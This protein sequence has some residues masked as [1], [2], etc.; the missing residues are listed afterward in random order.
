MRKLIL[1]MAALIAAIA[2]TQS[3]RAEGPEAC[4]PTAKNA[5]Y[6]LEKASGDAAQALQ[7]WLHYCPNADQMVRYAEELR[8]AKADPNPQAAPSAAPATPAP[9]A[10][11]SPAPASKPKSGP[12]G[13]WAQ[14]G[15]KNYSDR[16]GFDDFTDTLV[17]RED[18]T[19]EATTRYKV[20][21][22]PGWH[23]KGCGEGATQGVEV[24]TAKFTVTVSG[25][26]VT[27]ARQGQAI[28]TRFEPPCWQYEQ[29]A[30]PLDKPWVLTWTNNRLKDQDGEYFRQPD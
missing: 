8:K 20:T 24:M 16:S 1:P 10:A 23:L 14:S 12:Y 18:G 3:A 2:A 26:T 5:K 13:T 17:I 6:Q 27:L 11:T 30:A 7:D 4:Q 19:A 29:S 15:R 22:N 25:S 9:A 21:F 28:R